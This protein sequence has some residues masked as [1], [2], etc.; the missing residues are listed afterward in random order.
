M[1]PAVV[2]EE[3]SFAVASV[4]DVSFE[5]AGSIICGYC[6]TV[7][8]NYKLRTSHFKYHKWTG[9]LP[10]AAI[11]TATGGTIAVAEEEARTNSRLHSV[12]IAVVPCEPMEV[13]CTRET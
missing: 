6:G 4:G 5:T 2:I 10:C 11:P 8:G 9:L 1:A 13:P 12:A 3:R 7:N